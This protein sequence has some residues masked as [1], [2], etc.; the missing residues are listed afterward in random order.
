MTEVSTIIAY[1]KRLTFKLRFPAGHDNSGRKTGALAV[2]TFS[3]AISGTR[4]GPLN[5]VKRRIG[6][7]LIIPCD[8]LK[9]N[10]AIRE[11]GIRSIRTAAIFMVRQIHSF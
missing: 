7:F 3:G 6:V 10:V 1:K 4:G 9:F 8:R 2:I 11:A 5:G